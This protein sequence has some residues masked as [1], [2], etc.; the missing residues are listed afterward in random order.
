MDVFQYGKIPSAESRT[1]KHV[2]SDIAERSLCRHHESL[3]IKPLGCAA[4][5][6]GA[7]K[8]WIR[9]WPNGIFRIS[10]VRRIEAQLRREGKSGLNRHDAVQRPS[11]GQAVS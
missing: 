7:C 4:Q 3:R 5:N 10:V 6:H 2:S 11:A 9:G 1:R 8:G